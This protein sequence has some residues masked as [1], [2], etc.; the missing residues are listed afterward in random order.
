MSIRN[1][2]TR[3]VPAIWYCPVC[4]R[5]TSMNMCGTAMPQLICFHGMGEAYQIVPVTP[6]ATE[7]ERFLTRVNEYN[8]AAQPKRITY[9]DRFGAVG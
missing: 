6:M 9:D 2:I 5:V 7:Y 3:P 8:A 4:G 1:L